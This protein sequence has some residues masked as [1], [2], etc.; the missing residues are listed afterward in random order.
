MSSSGLNTTSLYTSMM[1]KYSVRLR[2]AK[3]YQVVSAPVMALRKVISPPLWIS[4]NTS[5]TGYF[6]EP[7]STE[8]S[9][10][11]ATP[12]ESCGTVMKET[13]KVLLGSSFLIA[14]AWQPSTVW[15]NR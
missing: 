7:M 4:P 11:W 2:V 15:V 5:F 13:Q 6:F 3:G 12:V 14:R 8:C 9:R 1:L 10:M